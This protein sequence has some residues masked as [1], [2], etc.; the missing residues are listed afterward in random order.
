MAY[1]LFVDS[2]ES[3]TTWTG[4]LALAVWILIVTTSTCRA[5][6]KYTYRMFLYTHHIHWVIVPLMFIHCWEAPNRWLVLTVLSIAI[7]YNFFTEMHSGWRAT[8][9]GSTTVGDSATYLS[10]QLGNTDLME[11]TYYMLMVPDIAYEWHPFSLACSSATGRAEFII[12]NLGS[13]TKKLH[14]LLED[15]HKKDQSVDMPIHVKGPY[16]TPAYMAVRENRP[17]LVAGGIG[18]TPFLSVLHDCI[19]GHHSNDKEEERYVKLFPGD[20]QRVNSPGGTC[21]NSFHYS[22]RVPRQVMFLWTVRDFKEIDF[23]LQYLLTMCDLIDPYDNHPPVKIK[24]FFT[25][26]A[27]KTNMEN[28]TSNLLLNLYAEEMGSK[29]KCLEVIAGRPNMSKEIEEFKPSAAFGCGP[30]GLMKVAKQACKENA[31]RWSHEEFKDN[32]FGDL[33]QGFCFDCNPSYRGLSRNNLPMITHAHN[34]IT[35]DGL[36]VSRDNR[37]QMN[38]AWTHN[39]LP[40]LHD[41]AMDSE[42][43]CATREAC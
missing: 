31:L 34:V 3:R 42:G 9:G 35:H 17:L 20:E 40:G 15:N 8:T 43:G 24:I 16:Y 41:T 14:E 6:K 4:V 38:P 36:D 26:L 5:A 22:L 23:F 10:L 11:G 21:K 27:S 12:K 2:N 7:A 32:T 25:P 39:S 18:L 19:Y 13:W 30:D 33:W 37:M 28:M 1:G 29:Y